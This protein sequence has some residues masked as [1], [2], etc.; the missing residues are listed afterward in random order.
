MSGRRAKVVLFISTAGIAL[1]LMAI[2]AAAGFYWAGRPFRRHFE[3]VAKGDTL[4]DVIHGPEARE[5][6]AQVYLDPEEAVARMDEFSWAYPNIPAPFVGTVPGPGTSYNATIDKYYLRSPQPLT[7]PKPADEIRV[8]ITGGST[9]FGSGAPSQ[10]RTIGAYLQTFLSQRTDLPGKV[11]VYTAA[12]PSWASTHERIFI[13]N[14]VSRLEPDLVISFSGINDV[15]WGHLGRNVLWFR[16]YQETHFRWLVEGVYKI[17]G[18]ALPE[19]EDV[20]KGSV[21]PALA[22][23][24]LLRNV[25]IAHFALHE[26]GVPY[27]FALQPSLFTT[28]KTLARHE[29]RSLDKLKLPY[30]TDCYSRF[31]TNLGALS[32]QGFRF[33][34]LTGIF[35][36]ET[37]PIFMDHYHFGDRGN[38]QLAQA[39][40]P[41]VVEML[42]ADAGR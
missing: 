28:K 20:S 5:S 41:A 13:V 3:E 36:D 11:R 26:D 38:R 12:N 14:H 19:T 24:L 6:L 15:H 4:G 40:V 2:G 42:N 9:A 32:L 37:A 29:R 21:D 35:D 8:F 18:K 22:S 7:M 33:V 16:S 10:D 1:I 31:Q 39:L 25:R 27:I 23:R 17:Y 34:D 30:F